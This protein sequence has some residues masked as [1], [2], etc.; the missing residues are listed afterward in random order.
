MDGSE[1]RD[2]VIIIG[3][4]AL[5]LLTFVELFVY[6]FV[7]VRVWRVVR[8]ANRLTETQFRERV[9]ALNRRSRE[10]IDEDALTLSSLSALA[11]EGVRRV[12]AR[13]KRK[14]RRFSAIRDAAATV[15]GRLPIGR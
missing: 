1:I 3:I 15:R 12:Q 6:L 13:R 4:G 9:L 2:W 11:I 10:L 8:A 7:G 5:A 14:P